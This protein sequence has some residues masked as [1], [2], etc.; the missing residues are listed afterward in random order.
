MTNVFRSARLLSLFRYA[1]AVGC[2]LLFAVDFASRSQEFGCTIE[3]INL[4]PNPHRTAASLGFGDGLG[5]ATYE[6]ESVSDQSVWAQSASGQRA[7]GFGFRGFHHPLTSFY[8]LHAKEST[9]GFF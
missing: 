4:T 1:S 3:R 8:A 2:L 5:I 6:R 7:Q 9:F